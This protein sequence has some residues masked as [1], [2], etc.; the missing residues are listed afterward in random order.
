MTR[1][2]LDLAI[3]CWGR[4]RRDFESEPGSIPVGALWRQERH[5]A[6]LLP[7]SLLFYFCQLIPRVSL[8]VFCVDISLIPDS[9]NNFRG[10]LKSYV[11][12]DRSRPFCWYFCWYRANKPLRRISLFRT[13]ELSP[14]ERWR[15]CQLEHVDCR[16]AR[17]KFDKGAW[18]PAKISDVTDG[19]LYLL[20]TP[21]NSR[22][23]NAA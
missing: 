13:R 2:F 20:V 11:K 14:Q 5:G 23:G 6:C 9:Q 1:P 16:A 21:N 19:G 8:L 12:V 7:G 15:E 4:S 18:C 3:L 10:A 17:L 22:P